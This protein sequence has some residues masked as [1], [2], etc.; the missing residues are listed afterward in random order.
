MIKF[1]YQALKDNTKIIEG[2]VEAQSL[3]EA[4]EQIRKLGFVPT[5]VYIESSV[6]EELVPLQNSVS[7]QVEIKHLSLSLIHI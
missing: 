7:K 4:R 6:Q 2:E 3:R 1:K 5:K